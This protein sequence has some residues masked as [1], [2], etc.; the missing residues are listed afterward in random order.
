RQGQCQ[1]C[2]HDIID[3]RDLK[4]YR[5]ICGYWFRPEDDPFIWRKYLGLARI[6]LVEVVCSSLL[7]G[8]LTIALLSAAC[9]WGWGFLVPLPV[10]AVLWLLAVSFFR[11]PERKIPNDPDALLSPADGTITDIG[12][13]NEPD[14]AN[15]R[16]FRISIFLSIFNV[17]VNRIPRSGQ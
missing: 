8:L 1:D 12:E 16:A 7:F 9:V 14:F 5:N 17:H 4:Y 6:G 11:D 2:R 3:S 15:G 10:V 13:V